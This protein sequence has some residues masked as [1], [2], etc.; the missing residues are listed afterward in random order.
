MNISKIA[1]I[2]IRPT[3]L[4]RA[5]KGVLVWLAPF[6]ACCVVSSIFATADSSPLSQAQLR[7]DVNVLQ[8]KLEDRSLFL[9]TS[10]A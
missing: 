10:N 6:F 7:E 5:R 9:S 4:S 1:W 2:A 3:N 8:R